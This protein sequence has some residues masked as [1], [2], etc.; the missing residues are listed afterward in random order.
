MIRQIEI[1]QRFN[2]KKLNRHYECFIIDLENEMAYYKIHERFND[3]RFIQESLICDDSWIAILRELKSNV[4]SKIHNLKNK[5]IEDFKQGF[6]NINLFEDFESE[7]FAY[8]EK[9]ELIYSCNINIYHDTNYEEYSFKNNFPKNWEK[10]ANLLINL[11][12]FDVCHL[13]CQKKLVTG[14]FYDFRKD[15]VYDRN[16]KKLSLNLIEFGHH[17]VLSMGLPRL[18]F[19]VDLANRKI[20]GYYERKLNDK[21]ILKILDLLDY[22]GVYLWI[23][24]DYQNK[25]LNHDLAIFDGYDWYLEL[26]FDGGVIWYIFGNN[27]YPDTYTAIALKIIELTGYDLLELNTIDDN[28]RKLFKK[29]AKRKLP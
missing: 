24:D 23:T 10:F 13:D 15:G 14:L 25:S 16:N 22:Y 7:K 17:S 8:F 21:D 6:E 5:E 12:G 26:V 11:V 1:S 2:F 4:S 27:E 3:E 20:D 19:V 29:Y 28:E 18:N 9:L